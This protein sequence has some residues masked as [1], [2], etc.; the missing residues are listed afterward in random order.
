MTLGEI[1]Q[2]SKR[3]CEILKKAKSREE[4]KNVLEKLEELCD[5]LDLLIAGKQNKIILRIP[6]NIGITKKKDFSE[7]EW[8]RDANGQFSRYIGDK[9]ARGS[10]G[11]GDKREEID[12]RKALLRDADRWESRFSA[13]E[14][15]AINGYTGEDYISIN[16][17]LR[18]LEYHDPFSGELIRAD[19]DE[20]KNID[21]AI[22]KFKLEEDIRV[23]R[24]TS[25]ELLE[26]MGINPSKELVGQK[27]CDKGYMS[28]S[29]SHKRAEEF[30]RWINPGDTPVV[31]DIDVMAGVRVGAYL[32]ELSEVPKEQEFLLERGIV[33]TI[34]GT[35][36][37]S[38]EDGG[39]K[40]EVF[41]IKVTME[42]K[43]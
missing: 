15:N 2:E 41:L 43:Q 18:R 12:N 9:E 40:K 39:I 29:V 22:S 14:R 23:Y 7:D 24:G 28:T 33:L 37:I 31:L 6:T 11:Y 10:K 42:G 34:T 4:M 21:S 13:D 8:E 3:Q 38:V 25:M 20:I 30:L 26:N 5:E 32:E 19:T 1:I 16:S 27:I 36:T 17:N 35:G